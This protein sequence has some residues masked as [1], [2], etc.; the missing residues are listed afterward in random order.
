MLNPLTH[1]MSWFNV[2]HI[3]T[4]N[5]IYLFFALC[6]EFCLFFRVMSTQL[7]VPLTSRLCIIHPKQHHVSQSLDLFSVQAASFSWHTDD[8]VD[9]RARSAARAPG[10]APDTAWGANS[11]PSDLA[12]FKGPT[13]E[14]RGG[15]WESTREGGGEGKRKEGERKWERRGK[16]TY[17]Y[18]FFPTSSPGWSGPFGAWLK[19]NK[20]LD[21]N[22]SLSYGASPAI[23]NHTV[24]STTSEF[25][26][27]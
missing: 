11:A 21:E 17:R 24:L 1:I 23:W 5:L 6:I 26:P 22:P 10:S 7:S 3:S 19:S 12:G 16:G 13:S 18:F 2:K 8:Y 15:H 14:G 25:A 20:A 27:L 4:F 9:L